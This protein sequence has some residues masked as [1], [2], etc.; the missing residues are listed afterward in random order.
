MYYIDIV[1]HLINLI[2]KKQNYI[3]FSDLLSETEGFLDL[4]IVNIIIEGYN[5]AKLFYV[6]KGNYNDTKNVSFDAM[7]NN[8]LLLYD[9]IAFDNMDNVLNVDI[10]NFVN[11]LL[12]EGNVNIEISYYF[13]KNP[14]LLLLIEESNESLVNIVKKSSKRYKIK[15]KELVVKKLPTEN[16]FDFYLYNVTSEES[17]S[18]KLNFTKYQKIFSVDCK[19]SLLSTSSILPNIESNNCKLSL[20]KNNNHFYITI[21][22]FDDQ[23]ESIYYNIVSYSIPS[24]LDDELCIFW[25][26]IKNFNVDF[27]RFWKDSDIVYRVSEF[28]LNLINNFVDFVCNKVSYVNQNVFLNS[29]DNYLKEIGINEY[30]VNFLERHVKKMVIQNYENPTNLFLR[31]LGIKAKDDFK[32]L[33]SNVGAFEF[34]KIVEKFYVEKK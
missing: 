23:Q 19:Y 6:F 22:V 10:K 9:Y 13:L 18:M 30:M 11:A 1:N 5:K 12:E 31:F 8:N 24:F 29:R 14:L 32:V 25:F 2:P 34:V 3:N 27:L 17:N 28:V 7:T 4:L 20:S 26:M 15:I 21:P 16:T 33:V